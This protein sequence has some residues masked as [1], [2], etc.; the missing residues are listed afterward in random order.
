MFTA[1][2]LIILGLIVYLIWFKSVTQNDTNGAASQKI[3]F[4]TILFAIILFVAVSILFNLMWDDI[5]DFARQGLDSGS[6]LYSSQANQTGIIFHS[7][8]TIPIIIVALALY[9]GL[10]KKGLKYMS[11][12]VPYLIASIFITLRLLF[13][14]GSH[15]I[16]EYQKA[17]MYIVLTFLIVVFSGIVFFVQQKWEQ[18]QKK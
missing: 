4:L 14:I 9:F 16:T 11:V 5:G 8:F 2:W 6:K 13:D 17:G 7:L 12:I 1:F 3:S 15:I 18:L 10:Y